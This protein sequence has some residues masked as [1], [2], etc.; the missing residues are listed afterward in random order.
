MVILLLRFCVV[1]GHEIGPGQNQYF[2]RV[3]GEGGGV[4]GTCVYIIHQEV[5][6]G[7][8]ESEGEEDG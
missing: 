7:S 5:G 6:N 1:C 2:I 3:K 4:V 8:D